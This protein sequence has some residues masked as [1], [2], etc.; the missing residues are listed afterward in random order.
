MNTK[1]T[2]IL[3]PV[4]AIFLLSAVDAH[5]NCA[6]LPGMRL[7]AK[8]NHLSLNDNAPICVTRNDDGTIDFT[9]RITIANPV[10]V[11]SGEVTVRQKDTSPNPQVEIEGDNVSPTNRV[12]VR[13]Q[14]EAELQDEFSYLI[15]V[16]GI[17]LLDPKVRVVDSNTQGM[18]QAYSLREV[19]EAWLLSPEAVSRLALMTLKEE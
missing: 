3:M 13:V 4:A 5:A 9:F 19:A 7:T 16:E 2:S 15:E 14:G 12:T 1:A 18:L 10:E 11:N 8:E 17:G 6:N